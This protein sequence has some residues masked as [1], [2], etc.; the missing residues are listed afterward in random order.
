M[1]VIEKILEVLQNAQQTPNQ[2]KSNLKSPEKKQYAVSG[3]TS[4]DIK[5]KIILEPIDDKTIK[6][7]TAHPDLKEN[8]RA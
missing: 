7:V 1:K 5:I 8:R 4:E 6:I 2:K 3:T